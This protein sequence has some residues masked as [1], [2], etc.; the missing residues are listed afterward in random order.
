MWTMC[1]CRTLWTKARVD[2]LLVKGM[3]GVSRI[4]ICDSESGPLVVVNIVK[5]EYCYL[6]SPFLGAF[7]ETCSEFTIEHNLL[8]QTFSWSF[9]KALCLGLNR[10][11]LYD[12]GSKCVFFIEALWISML[13]NTVNGASMIMQ[14]CFTPLV[15]WEGLREC[16]ITY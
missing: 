14:S 9:P 5:I 15:Y 1:V 13:K 2:S 10:L 8:D 4:G 7:A 12:I 11:P 6:V 3:V 16:I